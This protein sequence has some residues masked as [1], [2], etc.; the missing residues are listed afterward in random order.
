M[1]KIGQISKPLMVLSHL[2]LKA[3]TRKTGPKKKIGELIDGVSLTVMYLI[4]AV[5]G[6][7]AL[8]KVLGGENEEEKRESAAL[9]KYSSFEYLQ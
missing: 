5:V 7:Q 8:G 2:S 9:L 4:L 1:E 3:E 6:K